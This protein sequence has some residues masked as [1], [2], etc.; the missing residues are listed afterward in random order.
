MGFGDFLN[1][2]PLACQYPSVV[3]MNKA[4]GWTNMQLREI[5]PTENVSQVPYCVAFHE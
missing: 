3:W 4:I 1:L 5:C 2:P